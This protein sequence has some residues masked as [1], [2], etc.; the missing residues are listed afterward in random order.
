MQNTE[1]I[2]FVMYLK[3]GN[4][5]EYCHCLRLEIWHALSAALGEA[6]I[7]DYGNLLGTSQSGPLLACQNPALITV[8]IYCRPADY[9]R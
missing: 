8:L 1:E 2:A 4:Q 5:A 6:G 7:L 3:P 9:A